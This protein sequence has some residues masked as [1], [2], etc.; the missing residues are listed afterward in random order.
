MPEEIYYAPLASTPTVRLAALVSHCAAQSRPAQVEVD[1]PGMCWVHFE[2]IDSQF[3]VSTSPDETKEV[4]LVTF[5]FVDDDGK[6]VLEEL[7]SVLESLGFSSEPD[8]EY[9]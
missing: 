3:V 4:G 1:S 5:E 9:R 2:G 7:S 6:E 8:A